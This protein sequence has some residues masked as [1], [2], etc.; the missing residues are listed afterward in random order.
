[1]RILVLRLILSIL[2]LPIFAKVARAYDMDCAI[3]LCMAGGFPP[4]AVCSAAY[5]EM[6]RRIT[7]WPVR[8]PYGICT[9]AAMPVQLGG[10]GGEREV[11]ISTPD[12]GWLRRTR[13]LWFR[14]ASYK[15]DSGPQKWDWSIHSC[16]FE[17]D[18]C[19][20]LFQVFRSR[21]PWP[22]GFVSENGQTIPYPDTEGRLA[23]F[24]RAVM[25]EFGD[26]AGVMGH[27]A[28]FAY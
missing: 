25:V 10:P 11:D 14:G 17:N 15:D 28:W 27:S 12:Y 20:V 6:I 21:T 23:P 5:A 16:D 26:H 7:P 18:N 24:H 19:H 3:M 2:T 9:Y 1:M 13:V 8:P 22:V 4:G